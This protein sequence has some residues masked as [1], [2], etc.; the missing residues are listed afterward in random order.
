MNGPAVTG[1]PRTGPGARTLRA[2][3]FGAVFA[4]AGAIAG[5]P[6]GALAQVQEGASDKIGRAHV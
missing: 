3:L 5:I 6:P 4:I 1:W 2:L